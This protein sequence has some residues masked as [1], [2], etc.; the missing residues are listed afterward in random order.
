MRPAVKTAGAWAEG[1]DPLTLIIAA[2]AT[3]LGLAGEAAV[4]EATK[5]AYQKL[6]AAIAGHFGKHP[7]HAEA[8]AAFDRD[9]QQKAPLVGALADSGAAQ[10][11]AVM[12]AAQRLLA[13]ADPAGQ[14]AGRY[15]L[16]V[17]GDVQG[18]VQGDHANVTMNFG[19]QPPR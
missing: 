11:P 10:D 1:M 13:A 7:Q 19:D 17:Q 14:A 15:Q 18:L 2:L 5:D 6:K 3:G 8:L 12:E 9:P 16:T 4:T